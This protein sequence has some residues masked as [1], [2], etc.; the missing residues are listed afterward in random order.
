MHLNLARTLLPSPSSLSSIPNS[1]PRLSSLVTTDTPLYS[2]PSASLLTLA[3]LPALKFLNFSDATAEE[4]QNAE[5]YYLSRIAC[6]L[7]AVGSS[8]RERWRLL[9]EHPRYAE[10]CEIYGEPVVP[11]DEGGDTAAGKLEAAIVEFTFYMI[12][13]EGKV[14]AEKKKDVP[15]SVDVYRL[16]G[17]VGLLFGIRPLGCRLIWETEEWDPVKGEEEGWSCSEDEDDDEIGIGKDK[18]I[19]ESENGKLVRREMELEDGTKDVGF[20]VDGRKARVRV[21]LR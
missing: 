10:L 14:M 21:E 9:E 2:L 4:R 6:E 19:A 13:K 8:E 15:R 1:F 11:R 5:L 12:D 20:W 7:A 3:R 18:A 16:K 17:I